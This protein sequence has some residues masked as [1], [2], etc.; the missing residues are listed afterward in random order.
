M[1][2]VET[3]AVRRP[4][5]TADGWAA[6]TVGVAADGATSVTGAPETAMGAVR[7]WLGLDADQA[8]VIAD[9]ADDPTV[10]PLVRARPLL[11]VPGSVDPAELALRTV[12]GQQVSVAAARTLVGRLVALL[13]EPGPDGLRLF[14]RPS[15]IAAAGQDAVRAI[16]LTAARARTAVGLAAALAEG[17]DLGPGAG[18]SARAA[19]GALPGIGPWT[20]EYVA[21]RAM[22]DLDAFPAHDLVLRRRMGDLDAAAAV[23]FAERWRPWRGYAAQYLWAVGGPR[24]A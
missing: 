23:R 13:G 6:V 20:V 2:D 1:E 10:G 3:G 12:L 4:V 24:V 14:P 21:L 16:G 17:L 11:R 19:L 8:A 18:P 22:R 7:R 9:L 15:V 5:P